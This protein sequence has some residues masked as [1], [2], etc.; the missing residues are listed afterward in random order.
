MDDV[1][2]P[3]A[4][5]ENRLSYRLR[6]REMQFRIGLGAPLGKSYIIIYCIKVATETTEKVL[7]HTDTSF[8]YEVV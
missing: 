7:I 8:Q 4:E 3:S 2:C 6:Y 1:A 5:N